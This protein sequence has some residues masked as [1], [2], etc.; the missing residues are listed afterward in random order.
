MNSTQGIGW[1][2]SAAVLAGLLLAA[3]GQ[4]ALAAPRPAEP[5]F[6]LIAPD[7]AAFLTVRVAGVLGK[8]GLQPD[9][10]PPWVS[11]ATEAMGISPLDVERATFICHGKDDDGLI[12]VR[13]SKLLPKKAIITAWLSE[14]S[15]VKVEDKV[16]H[17]AGSGGRALHFVTP[18]LLVGGLVDPVTA[19]VKR[20]QEN[21]LGDAEFAKALEEAD[22]HDVFVWVRPEKL[23]KRQDMFSPFGIKAVM[24]SFDFGKQFTGELHG[25]C[26]DEA[27]AR[28]AL[29]PL[30]GGLAFLRGQ[31]LMYSSLADI[32]DLILQE[33]A[34]DRQKF[35]AFPV[36]L[37]RKFEEGLQKA[38]MRADGN[39]VTLSFAIPLDASS[40]RSEIEKVPMW[41]SVLSDDASQLPPGLKKQA[42]EKE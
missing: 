39:T 11:A 9:K 42:K 22:H 29:K 26:A 13:S 31:M 34:K 3:P 36:E 6:D 30:R 7:C 14:P 18:R 25:V 2:I 19:C 32:G 40:I 20:A 28:Q 24:A 33:N 27:K 10:L 12:I 35:E 5:S 21:Q 41:M 38:V 1:G 15:E 4:S 17:Q 23:L 16:I 8:S 37:I